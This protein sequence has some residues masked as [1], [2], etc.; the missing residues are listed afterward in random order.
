MNTI[1]AL[2]MG[3]TAAILVTALLGFAII[4]W[5]RKLHFGQTILDIGP[6]WHE[7]KQGTP[8]MGGLMFI[9]GTIAAVA[10]T[11]ITDRLLGGD[12]VGTSGTGA[13]RAE[14]YTKF[15]SGIIFALCVAL[16]GFSDDY[17]KVVKKR[18][19]GLT[20]IQKTI[21]Q[22]LV[23][24]AYLLG[25]YMCMGGKPYMFIPFAGN[26][27]MGIFFWI[28]GFAVIYAAINAVNFTDGIDGLCSSVTVTFGLS[29][30]II[31]YMHRFFGVSLMAS[32]LIGSCIG[33]LIWNHNPAKVFMG[34]TGSMFLGGMVVAIAYALNCPLILLLTGII[35]V[36]EGASDVIQIV[37]FKITH[38]KRIFKMAPIHHHFEMSGWS[39]KK[40]VA[41]FSIVNA[42]G[43]AA[44][45]ALMYFG[46]Y[47]V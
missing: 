13:A 18:N 41:V 40:I 42:V 33:F 35:Y 44:A 36:I 20:E 19:L 34:D 38:G 47:A 3:A 12:I 5:L 6:K 46:G 10:V 4:P 37:Y 2:V 14:L 16:I 32:V 22:S 8:T 27:Q 28:F 43:G 30:C 29:M 17:I 15:Y 23:I 26:V 45:I 9:A 7:K 39:E 25:L 31:A 21:L 11:V 24:I 1:A